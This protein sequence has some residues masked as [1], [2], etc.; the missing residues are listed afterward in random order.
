[1]IAEILAAIGIVTILVVLLLLAV[2]N[3]R[4]TRSIGVLRHL[5]TRYSLPVAELTSQFERIAAWNN[6]RENTAASKP[7]PRILDDQGYTPANNT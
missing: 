3:E 5:R 6:E 1:M 7:E 2:M 4:L